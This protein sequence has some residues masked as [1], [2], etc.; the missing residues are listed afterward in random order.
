MR[1]VQGYN[2]I[3]QIFTGYFTEARSNI[4]K[5]GVLQSYLGEDTSP[6][7]Q[8]WEAGRQDE[9]MQLVFQDPRYIDWI[10]KRQ[11]SPAT[12]ERVQVIEQPLT[13]YAAWQLALFA[14]YQKLGIE[15]VYSAESAR[16]LG[17]VVLPDSDV[18]IIDNQ[19]VLQW[20]YAPNSQGQVD[21]GTIWDVAAGDDISRPISITADLQQKCCGM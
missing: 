20:S 3:G 13:T 18:V 11:A 9:S 1:K 8:A 19:R 14:E 16:L 2:E 12:F 21:G 17:K 4:F 7:W 6:S 10:Q 5:L 15:E